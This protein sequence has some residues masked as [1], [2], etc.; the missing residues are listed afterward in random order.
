MILWKRAAR[1]EDAPLS[2]F[3]RSLPDSNLLLALL[4]TSKFATIFVALYEDF[5][6]IVRTNYLSFARAYLSVGFPIFVPS[7]DES[8]RTHDDLTAREAITAVRNDLTN[9]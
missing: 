8:F 3:Q 5:C 2:L 9:E 4:V 7:T 6:C 1:G